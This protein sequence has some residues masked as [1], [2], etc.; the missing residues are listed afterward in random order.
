MFKPFALFW[1]SLVCFANLAGAGL[2]LNDEVQEYEQANNMALYHDPTGLLTIDQVASP[3]LSGQFKPLRENRARFTQANQHFW[4][5]FTLKNQSNRRHWLLVSH[6]IWLRSFNLYYTLPQGGWGKKEHGARVSR[7]LWPYQHRLLVQPLSLE[8]S[9]ETTFYLEIEANELELWLKVQ[10]A[11]SLGRDEQVH[12]VASM[13][14][15][16]LCLIM[17]FYNLFLAIAFKSRSYYYYVLF[18][19]CFALANTQYGGYTGFLWPQW[20]EL[21]LRID[22]FFWWT[23]LLTGTLFSLRFLQVDR[24]FPRFNRKLLLACWVVGILPLVNLFWPHP[25]LY[26]TFYYFNL[27]QFIILIYL[28]FLSYRQGHLE[29]RFY[30]VGWG[31]LFFG[32]TLSILNVLGVLPQL[33]IFDWVRQIGNAFEIL[34]FSLALADR[35]RLIQKQNLRLQHQLAERLQTEVESRTAQLQDA[36]KAKDRFFSIISHDLK[37]PI[38]SMASIFELMKEQ[39]VP[40][41]DD[42][43]DNL[44]ETTHNLRSLLDD[45]LTWSRSQEG[46]LEAKGIDFALIEPAL[47]CLHLLQAQFS[48]KSLEVSN[49]VDPNA[50]VHAD[51]AMVTTV[52]R[53][54]VGNAIKFTPAG[55]QIR[56]TSEPWA[57][58]GWRF[59]VE[60]NGVGMEPADLA[61]IFDP[62]FKRLH[63]LGT[64][65]E[66]GS[67]M[68][69]ILVKEFIEKNGGQVGVRSQ[70]GQGSQFWFSLPPAKN[71]RETVLEPYLPKEFQQILLVEDSALHRRPAVYFLSSLGAEYELALDGVEAVQMASRFQFD[72]ILMDIDLPLRNGVEATRLIKN[73]PGR[74]PLILALTSFSEAA[75]RDKYGENPFDGH[76][77]KPL[78]ASA[79]LTLLASFSSPR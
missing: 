6:Y 70:L 27:C 9:Q 26:E 57:A 38:G 79:L 28:G 72:L 20:Y 15:L 56:L 60:D 40:L 14:Y 34:F 22:L 18:V 41:D 51:R 29:A 43:I 4:I 68:G 46:L 5:R 71:L 69:L 30:L 55:G 61:H 64:Q 3:E 35:M 63:R 76:L 75:I 42:L 77:P 45:L 39:Q 11:D 50:R 53:N 48:H 32:S 10:T 33:G 37:G 78:E 8:T 19:V 13:L 58:G 67:G 31:G 7:D 17:A 16:G 2:V 54:L 1:I 66:L 25:S 65:K 74:S 47:A 23:C 73:L 21:N 36:L 24:R 52:I 12:N 49:Q 44:T 62:G 59:L